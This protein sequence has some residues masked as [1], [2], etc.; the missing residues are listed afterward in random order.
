MATVFSTPIV[1][2]TP[3]DHISVEWLAENGP[4][5]VEGDA[6]QK[7]L[8]YIPYTRSKGTLWGAPAVNG[9]GFPAGIQ[10]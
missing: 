1:D 10:L 6:L 4:I 7:L 3:L 9:F 2:T 5:E 8:A